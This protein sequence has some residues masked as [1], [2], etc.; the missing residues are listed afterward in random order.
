MKSEQT[1]IQKIQF[2]NQNVKCEIIF[3][4]FASI[5]REKNPYKILHR[6]LA[7]ILSSGVTRFPKTFL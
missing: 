2:K 5:L 1:L 6:L 7:G 3:I 4:L